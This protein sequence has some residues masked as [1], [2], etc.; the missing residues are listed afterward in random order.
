MVVGRGKERGR[1][2]DK[3]KDEYEDGEEC[4]EGRREVDL[5]GQVVGGTGWVSERC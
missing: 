4:G 1:R 2:E 3:K 5:W